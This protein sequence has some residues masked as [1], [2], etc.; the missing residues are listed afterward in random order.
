MAAKPRVI[1]IE[2]H[3]Y[4]REL[5]SHFAKH[6]VVDSPWIAERLGDL[7]NLRIKEMD[8]AGIDMQ[9]LSHGAQSLHLLDA[10]TAV[11]LAPAVN[12]RLHQAVERHPQRFAAFAALPT[13]DPAAAAAELERAVTKLGFKGAMVHGRTDGLFLDDKRFWPIFERAAALDVPIYLHPATTPHPAVMEAYFND[14]AKEFPLFYRSGWGYTFETGTQA[15]RLVL[16]G[17]FDR[18]PHLKM[19]LGHLG[20]GIPLL[21]WRI[22][23]ALSRSG[24]IDF[25]KTFCEH[26][27]ITTSGFF[28][29]PALRCCIEEMGIDRVIFSVDYPYMPN[30]RAA[31]WIPTIPLDDNDKAKLLAGNVAKLLKL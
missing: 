14:Y 20:E 28:S 18:Y 3:Y 31:R 2:E 22:D 19:I 12:D 26:F 27:W 17:V 11:R 1:A 8:E 23:S 21:L 4:D 13:P 30:E 5:H 6:D 9:V 25:R 7:S 29:N 15:I 10:E 24:K 16:S